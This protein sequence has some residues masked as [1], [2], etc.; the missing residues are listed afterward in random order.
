M[1]KSAAKV[2][3]E[4]LEDGML[5]HIIPQFQTWQRVS[6]GV[7]IVVW[8]LCGLF[9]M[10]GV[11]KGMSSEE[12]TFVFVFAAFWAYFL[13]YAARLLIW[14]QTGEELI[15]LGTSQLSYKKSW[16]G[17]GKIKQYDWV[18]IK[19]IGLVNYD[20]KTFAKS[21]SDAFWTMGGEMIGF[22]SFGRKEAIGLKL[23]ERQ[24]KDLV[25]TLTKAQREAKKNSE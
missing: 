11:L 16:N 19:N 9:A 3:M 2:K 18:N 8:V 22:E 24:A 13:F 10:L 25:K 14:S 5:I 20:G 7:W 21:Y 1:I 12:Q 4:Q 15:Q 6:L 17:I 23:D